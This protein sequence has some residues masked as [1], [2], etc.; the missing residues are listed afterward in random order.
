MSVGEFFET[1]RLT[2]HCHSP[3]LLCGKQIGEEIYDTFGSF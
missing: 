3:S 1:L 2:G